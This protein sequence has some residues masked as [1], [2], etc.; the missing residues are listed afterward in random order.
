MQSWGNFTLPARVQQCLAQLGVL[1]LQLI[2]NRQRYLAPCSQYPYGKSVLSSRQGPAAQR[3]KG[4]HRTTV[5]VLPCNHRPVTVTQQDGLGN[6]WRCCIFP[7]RPSAVPDS[8]WCTE[9]LSG[10]CNSPSLIP[11]HSKGMPLQGTHIML[12]SYEGLWV[13]L[14]CTLFHAL[15][16]PHAHPCEYPSLWVAKKIGENKIRFFLKLCASCHM[17]E[18][19]L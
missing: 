4:S 16:L 3:G 17:I 1:S 18:A 7:G 12:L 15:Q 2:I 9:P 11:A 19:G 14:L 10:S 13:F 8:P 6:F 5:P